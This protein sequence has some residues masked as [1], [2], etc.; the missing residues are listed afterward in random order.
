MRLAPALLALAAATATVLRG[1]PAGADLID[2]AERLVEKWS[3]KAGTSVERRPPIFLDH[4]RVA[5]L[6]LGDAKPVA[7]AKDAKAGCVTVVLLTPRTAEIAIVP[8][9]LG[10][11]PAP[12]PALPSGH[13]TVANDDSGVVRSKAGVA[14]FE[15]CGKEQASHPL[16]ADR[17][18]VSAVSLRTTVEVL[19][20]RSA[21]PL[22]SVESILPERSVGPAAPRGNAG[23]PLD[24]GPILERMARVEKRSRDDG[25]ERVRKVT[26]T[27]SAVGTG[28]IDVN[29]GEGCHSL[30][31]LADFGTSARFPNDVDA[32]A[33]VGESGRM[34]A[35][36]RGESPDAHLELC[37]G[38]AT[39][40][41]VTFIGA[42]GAASV[43]LV[44][45]TWPLPSGIP[46][47]WGA[48]TRGD[49][50][51]ALRRRHAPPLP[52]EPLGS[53]MGVQGETLAPFAVEPG[54]C[55]LAAASLIRGDVKALGLTV[56]IGDRAP[57]DEVGER[58]EAALVAF[59]AVSEDHAALRIE[60]RGAQ[61]WWVGLIWRVT[62]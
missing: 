13:P 3:Q 17:L 49:V 8:E 32:E 43:T 11:P 9:A 4:G 60:A 21:A 48:E 52:P 39:D 2:D 25:A 42:A 28:E 55:Y 16:E 38:E 23:R 54:Q 44:D 10:A 47:E 26:M 61:P 50:A 57:H 5:A 22:A 18:L 59:C 35:R 6:R 45:A 53:V 41:E 7:T 40:I 29:L 33:H 14:M 51:A 36:D 24:P 30:D 58:P 12:A 62:K 1:E 27:P 20:A 19:V 31:L 15:R 37:L 34:L 46:T 56:E